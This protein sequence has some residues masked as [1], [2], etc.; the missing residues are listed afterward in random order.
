MGKDAF[1]MSDILHQSLQEFAKAQGVSIND[2]ISGILE[3]WAD[4]YQYVKAHPEV[5]GAGP[6]EPL[7]LYNGVPDA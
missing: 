7:R 5:M 3:N 6:G 2:V 4:E 1:Q